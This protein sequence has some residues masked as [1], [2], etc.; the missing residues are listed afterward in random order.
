MNSTVTMEMLY[1]ELKSLQ[2]E[3]ELVKY[4]VIPEEKIS[5][6]ELAKIRKTKKEMLAGKEFTLKEVFP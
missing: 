4:A 6:K 1:K 2:K 5:T 3:V